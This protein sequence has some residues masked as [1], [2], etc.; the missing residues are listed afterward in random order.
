MRFQAIIASCLVAVSMVAAQAQ[1]P[2]MSQSCQTCMLDNIKLAPECSTYNPNVDPT[3]LSDSDKKCFCSVVADTTWLNKCSGADKCGADYTKMVAQA[4]DGMKGQYCQ[5]Y[6]SSGGSGG[7]SS[8]ST[9]KATTGVAIA[10]G[11][12]V[13]QAVL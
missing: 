13:V 7:K 5:G 12:A 10:L 9:F 3:K 2:S 4:Y 8:A 1:D 6:T 11:A